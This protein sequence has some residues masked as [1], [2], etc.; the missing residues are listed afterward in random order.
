MYNLIVKIIN[1]IVFLFSEGPIFVRSN[2]GNLMIIAAGYRFYNHMKL[3]AKVRWKCTTVGC[4]AVL[5]T[6]NNEVV[7]CN[8]VHNH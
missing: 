6:V 1:N 3:G 2:R 4:R 8:L 7:K 5:F